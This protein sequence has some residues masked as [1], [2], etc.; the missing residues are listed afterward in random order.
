MSKII[1]IVSEGD[2]LE[3]LP[4]PNDVRNTVD[5]IQV[6]DRDR[7]MR[8]LHT[9]AAANETYIRSPYNDECYYRIENYEESAWQSKISNIANIARYLGATKA[10]FKVIQCTKQTRDTNVNVHAS[11]IPV[12]G[13]FDFTQNEKNSLT[14]MFN[15]SLQFQNTYQPTPESY[16]KA[17]ELAEKH[18]LYFNN[19]PMQM[20]LAMRNP[21]DI[22][23]TLTGF[24][25]H[26]EL[27]S[28][29]NSDLKIAANLAAVKWIKLDGDFK[30]ATQYVKS[31]SV[32]VHFDFME[33]SRS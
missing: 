12:S 19:E 6:S 11:S 18:H 10:D 33:L 1:R 9:E 2:A 14:N 5:F 4:M 21:N 29:T 20:M 15:T 24:N 32:D 28:E 26:I 30:S 16:Q 25:L 27:C 13:S 22:A 31:V 8:I 3:M 7:I 23:N 17:V